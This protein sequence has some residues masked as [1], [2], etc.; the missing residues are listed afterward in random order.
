M[1]VVLFCGGRGTRLGGLQD[2]IPKPMIRVGYR[3]ILW[4]IMKY[5]AHFGH[6][7]FI[8]CLGYK[9]DAI[10]EY[11][12]NYNEYISDNFTM[13]NGKNE[14]RRKKRDLDDWTIN[15]VDTGI[16]ANIGQRLMAVREYLGSDKVFLA[17]YADGLCDLDL[18]KMLAFF[19]QSG[20]TACFICVHPSQTF[21]VVDIAND[22]LVKN[23]QYVRDT[24]LMIN[25][26]FFI[27]KNEVFN[28]MRPGEELVVEPF[29]RLMAANQLVGYRHE[30]FWC[31]DTFKEHQELNDM[32]DLG[33]TPWAVWKKNTNK[34]ENTPPSTSPVK[35]ARGRR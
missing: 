1:K 32:H 13:R 9:A 27:F 10:K 18:D 5:Y 23:I 22:G 28:Y 6:K 25:G 14:L 24:N 8:L 17:N 4:H 31:M 16:N 3:P 26:G 15:F 34:Q 29:Q 21:H 12:L 19:K 11:F 33:N 7:E 30:R 20:K 35:K 2:G